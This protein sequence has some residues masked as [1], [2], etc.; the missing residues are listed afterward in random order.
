MNLS[1]F[2]AFQKYYQ[3]VFKKKG[4]SMIHNINDDQGNVTNHSTEVFY[5]LFYKYK[6]NA[7]KNIDLIDLYT[8]KSIDHDKFEE[9]YGLVINKETVYVSPTVFSLLLQISTMEYHTLDWYIT[10]LKP[11][12]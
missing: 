9:I 7:E 8:L 2:N 1:V 5:N 10:R 3:L 11:S 12:N 6:T 4:E